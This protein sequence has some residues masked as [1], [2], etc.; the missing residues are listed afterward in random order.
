M[1][2]DSNDGKHANHSAS[3]SASKKGKPEVSPE[4]TQDLSIEEQMKT[5]K[6]T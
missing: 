1:V 2:K 5:S 4:E 3:K 6:N